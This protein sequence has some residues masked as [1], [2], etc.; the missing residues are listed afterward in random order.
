MRTRITITG[1]D[2]AHR[3]EVIGMQS[4]VLV[5]PDGLPR[6]FT[7]SNWH[8]EVFD[9]AMAN[10]DMAPIP[11]M[12]WLHAHQMFLLDSFFMAAGPVN[13]GQ[14]VSTCFEEQLRAGLKRGIECTMPRVMSGLPD[15][16][17]SE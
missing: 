12:V 3:A 7:F 13:Q 8:W 4:R 10:D 6:H 11:E 14:E 9:R 1:G 16:L 15:P 2:S 5:F 17:S